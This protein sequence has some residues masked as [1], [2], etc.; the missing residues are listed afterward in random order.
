[1]KKLETFYTVD[2][3][4]DEEEYDYCI[5]STFE[6]MYKKINELVEEVKR[7]KKEKQD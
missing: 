3:S 5:N 1:M 7:L 2:R 4:V 6:M